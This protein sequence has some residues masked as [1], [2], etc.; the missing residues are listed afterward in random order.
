MK[1][2]ST[3]HFWFSTPACHPLSYIFLLYLHTSVWFSPTLT[4]TGSGTCNAVLQAHAR[5]FC[6]TL[7][8]AGI[9]VSRTRRLRLHWAP[10]LKHRGFPELQNATLLIYIL[11]IKCWSLSMIDM[12][13]N[14]ILRH[15]VIH[16]LLLINHNKRFMTL[17]ITHRQYFLFIIELYDRDHIK[18]FCC[19]KSF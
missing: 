4:P 5:Q 11:L 19:D 9:C 18:M 16:E 12:D 14:Y 13:D 2:C 6:A 17:H 3:G 1:A 7:H 15:T 8:I 10:I